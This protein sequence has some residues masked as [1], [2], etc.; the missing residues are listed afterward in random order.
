MQLKN[1]MTQYLEYSYKTKAYKLYGK[2]SRQKE[3]ISFLFDC[4]DM[5]KYTDACGRKI[6]V[7]KAFQSIKEF[8]KRETIKRINTTNYF[9]K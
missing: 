2:T 6:P 1:N 4:W 9:K 8:L 7:K 3:V 5:Q